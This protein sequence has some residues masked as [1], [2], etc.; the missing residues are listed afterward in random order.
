MNWPNLK[1]GIQIE[2]FEYKI[3]LLLRWGVFISGFFLTLGLIAQFWHPEVFWE[4]ST[5]G[6]WILVL[7]PVVRVLS[8]SLL[9]SLQKE[10]ALSLLAL[11]VFLLLGI[12]FSQGWRGY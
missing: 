12:S 11:L 3:G 8:T 1:K 4:M 2:N 7:L 10:Y 6:L 9:F 5:I